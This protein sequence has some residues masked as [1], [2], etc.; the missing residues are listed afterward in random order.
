[1]IS[2]LYFRREVCHAKPIVV[3]VHS[4]NSGGGTP[5]DKMVMLVGTI[6]QGVM[7]SAGP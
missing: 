4:V 5:M 7:R 3:N 2:P 1:M 6:G